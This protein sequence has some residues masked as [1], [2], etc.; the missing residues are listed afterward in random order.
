MNTQ[1]SMATPTGSTRASRR[2]SLAISR[3]KDFGAYPC[4]SS[5]SWVRRFGGF[6]ARMGR[7]QERR[8]VLD[9]VAAD[10]LS[11]PPS[12]AAARHLLPRG[13]GSR[14]DPLPPGEGGRRPG[15]GPDAAT[16]D[17]H[18][19]WRAHGMGAHGMG[20]T[21]WAGICLSPLG[22]M[23]SLALLASARSLRA[24][25][26]RRLDEASRLRMPRFPGEDGPRHDHSPQSAGNL[27]LK[28]RIGP[29]SQDGTGD[30]TGWARHMSEP[31][32]FDPLF[33]VFR[34]FAEQKGS[35][36]APGDVV[37]PASDRRVDQARASHRHRR[38]SSRS[39]RKLPST[40]RGV[41]TWVP[42]PSYHLPVT[43]YHLGCLSLL[44]LL[45]LTLLLATS[46]CHLRPTD[47]GHDRRPVAPPDRRRRHPAV[48]A[49]VAHSQTSFA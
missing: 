22:C 34:P 47:P 43:S 42:V 45:R 49:P 13:E 19:R 26:Q 11:W 17:G 10:S 25:S 1:T 37:I 48:R 9:F 5:L 32:I 2:R 7:D 27:R 31:P 40:G 23:A 29:R 38:V 3:A 33:A 28:P 6:V 30:G 20:H 36:H 16:R 18:T 35:P 4:L 14:R 41:K 21:G 15:E 12:S 24:M 39:P 44:T 46:S 8:R